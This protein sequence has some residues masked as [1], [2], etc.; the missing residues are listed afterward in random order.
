LNEC[1]N[2]YFCVRRKNIPCD[3]CDASGYNAEVNKLDNE[4]Y[5]FDRT[6]RRWCA[7]ITQ[8]EVQ[9]LWER[10]R[11]YDFKELPTADEV[12]K[13]FTLSRPGHLGHDAINRYICVETRAK[14]MGRRED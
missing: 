5:D 13:W 14:S 12:N 3:A 1:V 8:D 6:G 4:W 11:L 2:F 7:K 9:A 10:G